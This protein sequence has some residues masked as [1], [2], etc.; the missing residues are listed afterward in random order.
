[1]FPLVT[2]N[3]LGLVTHCTSSGDTDAEMVAMHAA[4]AA[5]PDKGAVAAELPASRSLADVVVAVSAHAEGCQLVRQTEARLQDQQTAHNQMDALALRKTQVRSLLGT[6]TFCRTSTFIAPSMPGSSS[7]AQQGGVRREVTMAAHQFS[8]AG[9]FSAF[10]K[11]AGIRRGAH[12]TVAACAAS[13]DHIHV[14]P[15]SA[16][17]WEPKPAAGAA[18]PQQQPRQQS[19]QQKQ[20]RATMQLPVAHGPTT[21][22]LANRFVD[23]L[24]LPALLVR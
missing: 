8:T 18:L 5:A 20:D 7:G 3:S 22:V 21:V 23:R 1:M 4:T 2:H 9:G 6:P 19:Q 13:P 16:S 15:A 24:V 10:R 14:A 17:D 12:V 11:A